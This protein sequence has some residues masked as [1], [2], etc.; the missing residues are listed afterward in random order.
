MAGKPEA[1]HDLDLSA[2]GFWESFWSFAVA[3][4]PLLVIWVSYAASPTGDPGVSRVVAVAV[5]SMAYLAAWLLPLAAFVAFAG[6]VGLGDRI[7]HYVV[8]GNWG[9]ALLA[10][11][12]W[13]PSLL[14]LALPGDSGF[15][16]TMQWIALAIEV[17]LG[18]RL[19]NAALAKGPAVAT[20]VYAAMFIAGLFCAMTIENMLLPSSP[21]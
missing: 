6:N 19:T 10:W 5:I 1:I 4:P 11:L 12:L 9:S 18:W 3:I 13:P 2:D 14:R 7:P 17:T 21:A 8:A 16:L 20:A 15:A